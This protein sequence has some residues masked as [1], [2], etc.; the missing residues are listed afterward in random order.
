MGT[1]NH[2]S[3]LSK[4]IFKNKDK[5]FL[6]FILILSLLISPVLAAPTTDAVTEITAGQVRFNA[7][8]GSGNGWFEWGGV[9]GSSYVWTTPN[10]TVSGAFT[11]TQFGAPMLS[12]QTYYVRACDSTGCGGEVSF[13]T[14]AAKMINQTWFGMDVI[15]IQR[16]GFN[17][18]QTIPIV[19]SPY[20]G[21]FTAWGTPTGLSSTI[22]WALLF[23]FIFLGYWLRQ[24][25]VT[26][27]VFM[28]L[29]VG[30]GFIWGAG[31]LGLPPEMVSIGQGLLIA[32]LA[33]ILMAWVSK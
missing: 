25:D 8:G 24:K 20:V 15:T 14:S 32:S 6:I 12:G 5:S 16:S 11:D 13:T 7:H 4:L 9:S 22:V 17:L 29:A 19:L 23:I 28:G 2:I 30:S 26:I 18:T 21:A 1:T 31:G 10:Q 27:L 33:G 3:E